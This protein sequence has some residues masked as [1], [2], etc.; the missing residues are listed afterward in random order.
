LMNKD[1]YK[2]TSE[3]IDVGLELLNAIEQAPNENS[4]KKLS[5]NRLIGS[6]MLDRFSSD[7]SSKPVIELKRR[8]FEDKQQFQM[9]IS[10]LRILIAT[11]LALPDLFSRMRDVLNKNITFFREK[12]EEC[13]L[14]IKQYEMTL[15]PTPEKF[16]SLVATLASDEVYRTSWKSWR[17]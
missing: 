5:L 17:F 16:E 12:L 4:E 8:A 6:M 10:E 7:L 11:K 15:L 3:S 13:E 9:L 14:R 1:E 2:K